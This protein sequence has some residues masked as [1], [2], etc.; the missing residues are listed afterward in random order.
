MCGRMSSD[1][2]GDCSYTIFPLPL[3]LQKVKP[4]S[5][6]VFYDRWLVPKIEIDF[7]CYWDAEVCSF[8]L[9]FKPCIPK[10]SHFI[11]HEEMDEQPDQMDFYPNAWSTVNKCE[12]S[13]IGLSMGNE[14]AYSMSKVVQQVGFTNL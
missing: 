4:C 13:T 3:L 7:P 2:S 8:A 12:L 11:S 6:L 1:S 10:P 14:K 5:F 9:L